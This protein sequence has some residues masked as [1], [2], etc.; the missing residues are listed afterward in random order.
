M[1]F[2]GQVLHIHVVR[3][4]FRVLLI[5]GNVSKF[6]SK[7]GT[8]ESPPPAWEFLTDRFLPL[9]YCIGT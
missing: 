9:L 7:S 1:D 4:H 3:D 8:I 6:G 2:M 5:L